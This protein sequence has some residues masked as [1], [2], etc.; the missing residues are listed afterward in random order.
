MK[1]VASNLTVRHRGNPVPALSDVSC[2]I[3]SGQF[4]VVAGP[5]GSG[6]TTLFRS[7]LGLQHL[8]S[9]SVEVEGQPVTALARGMLARRIAA[10]PQREEPAFPLTVHDAVML[11]RWA[12]LGALGRPGPDDRAAID[13]ALAV[14]GLTELADRTTDRMSGGEWQRVRLARALAAQ[15]ELLLLDEPGNSL[16]LAHEM[17]FHELLAGLVDDGIGVMVITHHLNPALRYADR[18]LLL[19]RGVLVAD[20]PPGAILT[21]ELLSRV[22]RWPVSLGRNLDGT[23]HLVPLR[24]STPISPDSNHSHDRIHE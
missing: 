15:P 11:G 18:L 5:N 23:L 19:D 10:L 4:V 13:K 22:Y 3:G 20:G 16:D 14:V 7:L 8:D 9:G 21:A 1:I 2:T 24:R 6:K 12:R 17:A